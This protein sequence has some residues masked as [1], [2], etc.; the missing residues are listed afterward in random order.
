MPGGETGKVLV[1][2]DESLIRRTARRIL[3][4]YGYTV[5]VAAD[6]SEAVELYRNARNAGEPYHA[7]V[8]DLTVPGGTG[9]AEA[10]NRLKDIDPNIRAVVSSGYSTDPILSN[11]ERYGFHAIACKPYRPAELAEAVRDAI[12]APE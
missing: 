7:V 5:D 2:D 6:G 8:L 4:A 9:G 10:L 11:Y 12:Q 3:E 1:M